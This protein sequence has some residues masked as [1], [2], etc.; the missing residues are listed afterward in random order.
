MFIIINTLAKI[1]LRFQ[2]YTG[3][4][5]IFLDIKCFATMCGS[6][7]TALSLKGV[8]NIHCINLARLVAHCPQGPPRLLVMLGPILQFSTPFFSVCLSPYHPPTWAS[9]ALP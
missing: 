2:F 7:Y 8:D 9:Q 1:M 4:I 6:S 5:W 3:M